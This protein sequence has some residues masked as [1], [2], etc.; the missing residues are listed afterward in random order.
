[1]TPLVAPSLL[2]LVLVLVEEEKSPC[3]GSAASSALSD[4]CIRSSSDRTS[5]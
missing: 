4:N 2:S 1:M 3:R 5:A